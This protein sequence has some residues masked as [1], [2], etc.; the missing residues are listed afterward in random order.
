MLE[1][2]QNF[3]AGTLII[4]CTYQIV[5]LFNKWYYPYFIEKINLRPTDEFNKSDFMA[6]FKLFGVMIVATLLSVYVPILWAANIF[7]LIYIVY[8]I[9]EVNRWTLIVKKLFGLK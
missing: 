7:F 8:Q 9:Y 3:T 1:N 5:L 4:L 6:H 2:I